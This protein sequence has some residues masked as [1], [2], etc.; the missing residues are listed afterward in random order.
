MADILDAPFPYI[1]GV[2]PHTILEQYDLESEVIKVDLDEGIVI[3]PQD[4]LA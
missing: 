4:S 2:E 1:I 3:V